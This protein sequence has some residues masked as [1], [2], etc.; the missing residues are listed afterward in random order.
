MD[1]II[2]CGP[3][4]EDIVQRAVDG[5]AMNVVNIRY[6]YVIA[7]RKIDLSNCVVFEETLFP[8]TREQV[9]S[10]T[11]EK[12]GGWY[13]Q[14]LV[15]FYAPL[16]ISSCSEDVLILDADTVV[17]KR[18]KFLETG[19][20]QF[21]MTREVNQAHLNHMTR[22]HPS[23]VPW[24]RQTSGAT[25]C[26][27][28]AKKYLVEIMERVEDYHKKDFWQAYVDCIIEKN[29]SGA[30]EYEIYWHYMMVNHSDRVRIRPLR[31]NNFGQRWEK[32]GGDYQ[33]VSYHWQNQRSEPRR[34][35][36]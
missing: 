26:G 18:I 22:L 32:D 36:F 33:Y 16:L 25:N 3:K 28:W 12:S 27:V 30:S 11:S 15:K 17:Y 2:L 34:S 14:Q 9:E 29:G 35:R 4:D 7:S 8:F 23:F 1:C 24:K 13:L 10:A 6:I 21:V 5:V 20:Y 19:K 31:W